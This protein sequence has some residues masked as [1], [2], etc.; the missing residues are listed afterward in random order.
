MFK[1]SKPFSGQGDV[2][3]KFHHQGDEFAVVEP[4]GDNSWYW[5]G[6]VSER[7]KRDVS[8][9]EMQLR[10]YVPS[11]FRRVLDGLVTLNFRASA[12]G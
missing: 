12:G 3:A 8:P 4:F 2:R 6:P 11:L 10:S 5:I 7:V 9:I 1:V